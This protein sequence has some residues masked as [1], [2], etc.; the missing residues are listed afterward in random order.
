[1]SGSGHERVPGGDAP[2]L[3]GCEQT[4]VGWRFIVRTWDGA[5]VGSLECRAEGDARMAE[6]GFRRS[7]VECANNGGDVRGWM[8]TWFD[9]M[10]DLADWWS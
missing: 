6:D 5:V 9:K 1:V 8:K 7:M 10:S 2:P 4:Q 3:I